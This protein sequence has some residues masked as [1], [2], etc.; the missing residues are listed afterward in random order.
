[1]PA[2]SVSPPRNKETLHPLSRKIL[3]G[4]KNMDS[5]NKHLKIL[6]TKGSIITYISC[7]QLDFFLAHMVVAALKDMGME[8]LV[9]RIE[10]NN[11]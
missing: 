5:Q 4:Q 7:K 10:P 2:G 6:I 8:F 11:I 3:V 1:M 9:G